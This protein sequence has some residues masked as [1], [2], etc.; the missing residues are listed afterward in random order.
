MATTVLLVHTVVAWPAGA[1]ETHGS[2]GEE[3]SPVVIAAPPSAAQAEVI[4]AK[5]AEAD[6]HGELLEELR[7]AESTGSAAAV[8]RATSAYEDEVGQS[9]PDGDCSWRLLPSITR[10]TQINSYYCGPATLV[11]LV[12]V[13]SVSITQSQAAAQLGTTT[14]GTAFGGG[15]NAP[16]PSA[17]TNRLGNWG[18]TYT[19][20][21]VASP[22]T[23]TDKTSFKNR[24]V[25][26][27]NNNWGVAGN[28]WEVRNGAKLV[29]HPGDRTI[30]HWVAI[31]GYLN[32]G[33]TTAYTDSVNGVPASVISWAPSVPAYASISSNTMTI[34][35]GGRGYVW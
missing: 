4:A 31:R 30:M 27:V 33:S 20:V 19:G 3:T 22:A 10:Q 14:A 16:M 28:T 32:Y 29:G 13:R 2:E 26:D 12:K 25:A 23:S 35:L 18:A 6:R 8:A 1:D 5:E 15:P 21:W 34:L 9:C 24:L 11:A 7:Q 17:L